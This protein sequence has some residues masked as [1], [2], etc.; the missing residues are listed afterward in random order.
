MDIINKKKMRQT[1][2]RK[3]IKSNKT[4]MSFS[5]KQM[6]PSRSNVR[7]TRGYDMNIKRNFTRRRR[8][9]MLRDKKRSESRSKN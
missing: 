6:P 5:D 7:R 3:T 2:I 4:R 9:K 1:K 8:E